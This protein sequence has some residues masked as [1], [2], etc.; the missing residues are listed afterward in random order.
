MNMFVF[1][2]LQHHTACRR[3]AIRLELALRI[4][5]LPWFLRWLV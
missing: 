3:H 4:R 1:I 2:R 5:L